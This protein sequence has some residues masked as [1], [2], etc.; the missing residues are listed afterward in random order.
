M[1]G[2]ATVNGGKNAMMAP[3]T[4]SL[5]QGHPS[6]PD[7]APK[8]YCAWLMSENDRD[9]QPRQIHPEEVCMATPFGEQ[10]RHQEEHAGE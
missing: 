9:G 8:W 3:W 5:T 10:A 2:A 4:W 7:R 6:A 1:P